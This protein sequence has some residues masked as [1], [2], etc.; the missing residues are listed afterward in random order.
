LSPGGTFSSLGRELQD[1]GQKTQS[2]WQIKAHLA[3][4][5]RQIKRDKHIVTSCQHTHTSTWHVVISINKHP[6]I[7]WWILHLQLPNRSRFWSLLSFAWHGL[8]TLALW[9]RG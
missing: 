9:P 6:R 1:Y 4:K 3:C 5:M 7:H 8:W 2:I